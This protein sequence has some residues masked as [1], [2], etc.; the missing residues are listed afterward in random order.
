M[1]EY[2]GR[3]ALYD[4]VLSVGVDAGA[5]WLMPPTQHRVRLT[6]VGGDEFLIEGSEGA[7]GLGFSRNARGPVTCLTLLE[8]NG[9]MLC[10]R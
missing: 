3:Y 5:L 9:T 1:G 4:L 8:Q 7:S 10:K 6:P 2:S